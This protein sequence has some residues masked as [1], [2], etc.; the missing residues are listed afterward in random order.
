MDVYL[1]YFYDNI[2]LRD[3]RS[4]YSDLEIGKIKNQQKVEQKELF[5]FVKIQ[6]PGLLNYNN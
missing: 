3:L 4:Q 2:Y 6:T 1:C 5:I